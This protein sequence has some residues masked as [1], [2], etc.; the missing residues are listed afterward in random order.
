[1]PHIVFL[2]VTKII[3]VSSHIAWRH[4]A[5]L[6][7]RE[8]FYVVHMA[9]GLVLRNMR[10]SSHCVVSDSLT[11]IMRELGELFKKVLSNWVCTKNRHVYFNDPS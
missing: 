7:Q 11:T 8:S 3:N 1:M 6:Q 2:G 10:V 9:H 4:A 5:H